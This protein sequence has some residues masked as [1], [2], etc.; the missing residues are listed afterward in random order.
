M[1][2]TLLQPS[3]VPLLPKSLLLDALRF[4]KRQK[5]DSVFSSDSL[6]NSALHTACHL[7][8]GASAWVTRH[9]G[10]QST[11][12]MQMDPT[13]SI[14]FTMN[15][16]FAN[17]VKTLKPVLVLPS[18]RDTMICANLSAGYEDEGPWHMLSMQIPGPFKMQ[19]EHG[20]FIEGLRCSL[21]A[22]L[23]QQISR[24]TLEKKWQT[25]KVAPVECADCRCVHTSSRDLMYANFRYLTTSQ[26]VSHSLCGDC[27]KEVYDAL[28][29]AES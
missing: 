16:V 23:N 11:A 4:S 3:L 14:D 8:N 7:L 10:S 9:D 13:Y 17:T 12:V 1:S 24:Q 27:A 6:F 19:R 18:P 5:S 2:A 20:V 25:S 26:A 29:Q 15:R 28:I 22:L 21:Q